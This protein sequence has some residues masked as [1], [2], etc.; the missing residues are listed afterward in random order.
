MSYNDLYVPDNSVPVMFFNDPPE[1]LVS[2]P[3][4]THSEAM[5]LNSPSTPRETRSRGSSTIPGDLNVSDTITIGRNVFSTSN[6]VTN[7]VTPIT[8]VITADSI[9]GLPKISCGSYI[10]SSSI[11]LGSNIS[12]MIDSRLSNISSVIATVTGFN[13]SVGQTQTK[14]EGTGG[15]FQIS[16]NIL[17]IINS[18][19]IYWIAIGF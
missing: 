8:S 5:N 1:Y 16:V 15:L 9:F 10:F 12:P 17:S 7:Q 19:K 14:Y 18:V 2:S 3:D 4:D 11:V 6:N 13:P